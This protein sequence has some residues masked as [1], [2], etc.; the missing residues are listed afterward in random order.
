MADRLVLDESGGVRTIAGGNSVNVVGTAASE[1]IIANQGANVT[2]FNASAGGASDVVHLA[3][4]I[5]D[6]DITA[7]GNTIEFDDQDVNGEE[8]T[9][10]LNGDTEIRFADG[11]TTAG[12]DTSGDA[13][14]VQ[15]G[16][17]DVPTAGFD[18]SAVTLDAAAT[19][20]A[21]ETG[22]TIQ[23]TQGDDEVDPG[24]FIPE[25]KTTDQAD[26]I[27]G[28]SDGDLGDGDVIDGGA[29]SDTLRVTETLDGDETIAPTVNDVEDISF[30]VNGDGTGGSTT[31]LNFDDITGTE[32][33]Y[34]RNPTGESG[35]QVT[36]TGANY[37]TGTLTT[38][39][40]GDG[41]VDVRTDFTNSQASGNN[42]TIDLSGSNVNTLRADGVETVNL[43]GERAPSEVA[44][45][46]LNQTT[47]LNVTG[48]NA[49]TVAGA[50]AANASNL[51]TVDAAGATGGLDVTTG[52]MAAGA[53]ITGSGGE[54][55]I[56]FRDATNTINVLGY[57]GDDVL[58]AGDQVSAD[59]TINGGA[60]ND[61]LA[62]TAGDVDDLSED[63]ARLDAISNIE[64]V[65]V[66]TNLGS[67]ESGD[68]DVSNF[69]ANGLIL[70][71]ALSG[72]ARTVSGFEDGATLRIEDF[73]DFQETLTLQGPGTD[74]EG[75][76]VLE[77]YA[78]GDVTDGGT[79]NLDLA[80]PGFSEVKLFAEDSDES[81]AAGN[82]DGYE[83][84]LSNADGLQELLLEG[85]R[86][87]SFTADGS[88]PN[89]EA[90][91]ASG[92][93]P[94]VVEMT[95]DVSIDLSNFSGDSGVEVVSGAGE[96]E[97]IGSPNDDIL[98]AGSN[99][100][101]L[102]GG[103]G[104]DELFALNRRDIVGEDQNENTARGGAGNDTID[105]GDGDDII[106]GGEGRDTMTGGADTD[107]FV[108]DSVTDST[109][110]NGNGPGDDVD[111]LRSLNVNDS[112]AEPAPNPDKIDISGIDGVDGQDVE[113]VPEGATRGTETQ[114]DGVNLPQG[115]V[116]TDSFL[117][118]LDSIANF[119]NQ[120]G[121]IEVQLLEADGGDLNGDDWLAINLDDNETI[122][123]NDLILEVSGF[124]GV[125]GSFTPSDFITG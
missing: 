25:D 62:L 27:L 77:V 94:G 23:L 89:L 52:D 66:L 4:S 40:G 24:T 113:I 32:E 117:S 91:E 46:D 54:D 7:Q 44:S 53:D 34:V 69:G 85:N 109:D 49:I 15:L 105:V 11:S 98:D 31:T 1:G 120:T 88:T 47:R 110:V 104:D 119:D 73:A 64:T 107:T 42:A 122:D 116:N 78:E 35:D 81:D 59:D 68:F 55:R 19:S 90:I 71:A 100:G 75:L 115:T 80:T 72:A 48:D 17:L 16:G 56:D 39:R 63:P 60:G 61:V 28:T 33:V 106:D 70:Q 58:L 5:A 38:V 95:G 92:I 26:T 97:L 29:G 125:I 79:Q 123:S 112:G 108:Y 93:Q 96:D 51:D 84:N 14:Q 111:V 76:E 102:E 22:Q 20:E 18:E 8:V 2:N 118:D 50:L 12:V 36:L 57:A 45:L 114:P 103:A 21:R 124:S 101:T 13:L 37:R 10:A 3:G 9:V 87:V 41:E 82:D 43:R 6:F 65:G 83:L 67:D 121:V 86:A 74:G 30:G 99:N